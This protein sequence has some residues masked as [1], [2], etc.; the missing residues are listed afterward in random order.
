MKVQQSGAHE[1]PRSVLASHD[2]EL[3]SASQFERPQERSAQTA[4][5]ALMFDS[6]RRGW[7]RVARPRAAGVPG[8]CV[9]LW[10]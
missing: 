10:R 7:R 6:R 9:A 2:R 8:G 3:R 5:E 1:Q 4:A